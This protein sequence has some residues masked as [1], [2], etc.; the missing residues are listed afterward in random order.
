L[1]RVRD[2]LERFRDA[3]ERTRN[4]LERARN[5]RK[6]NRRA[7]ERSR[8]A[9]ERLRKALER[10]RNAFSRVRNAKS[11]NLELIKGQLSSCPF[12]LFTGKFVLRMKKEMKK[13]L[14][15]VFVLF[16]AVGFAR[17]QSAEVTIQLNEPFFDALLDAIFK[18]AGAPEFPLAANRDAEKVSFTN[19][20]FDGSKQQRTNEACPETIKLQREIDGV[21]TAVR[22]RDGR[23]Y[24]PLAFTGSYNPPLIGCVEFSGVADAAIDLQFDRERQ[25]LVGYVKVSSVNLSGAGGIGSSM[26]AGLVQ[27]SI[28][29]KINPLQILAMDKI[30]FVVPIQNSGGLRLKAVGIKN[31]ISNGVLNVRIT[32][33]F[34]KA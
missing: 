32:Y 9:L 15:L 16:L 3:L 14:S 31:E 24:A 29:R 20:A 11:P 12:Y 1:E 21:K 17:G 8:K 30:S 26:I 34:L 33:E 4:A 7:L 19:A 13:V 6:P 27:G 2:A 28:D 23:V 5:A 18:H 10:T 25:A 22:F